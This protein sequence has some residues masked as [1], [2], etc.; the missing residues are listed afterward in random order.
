M[1]YLTNTCSN[2]FKILGLGLFP[3][4]SQIRSHL[5]KKQIKIKSKATEVDNSTTIDAELALV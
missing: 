5:A 2:P 4:D 1:S 3:T